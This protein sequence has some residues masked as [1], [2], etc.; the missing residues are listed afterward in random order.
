MYRRA[1][2]LKLNVLMP[3][4]YV[5]VCDF[6]CPNRVQTVCK[7]MQLA[8]NVWILFFFKQTNDLAQGTQ[9]ETKAIKSYH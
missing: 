8:V 7:R 3:A 2:H 5:C 4:S 6:M 9:N 1:F